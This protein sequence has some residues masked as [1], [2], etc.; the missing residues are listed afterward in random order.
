[1]ARTTEID[2]RAMELH[3]KSPKEAVKFL[4]GYCLNNAKSV[5]DAWWKLGDDLWVKYN[6]LNQYNTE[7]RRS[8]RIPTANPPWWDRAVR[9]IDVLTEPEKR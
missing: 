7:T 1:M 8:G 6:H 4:T 5:T 9:G 3:K 2:R